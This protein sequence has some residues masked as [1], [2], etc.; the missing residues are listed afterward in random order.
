MKT[1]DIPYIGIKIESIPTILRVLSNSKN[2]NDFIDYYTK[3]GKSEKTASEYL[4]SLRNLKLAKKNS[5]MNTI[6][7]PSGKALIEDD[8]ELLYKNLLAHC[9]RHFP[10][11]KII[12]EIFKEDHITVLSELNTKLESRGYIIK[13]KQTLSSF[14]KLFLECGR[15]TGK[16]PSIGTNVSGETLEYNQFLKLLNKFTNSEK[17]K[18]F[19]LSD[20]FSFV[21]VRTKISSDLFTEYLIISQ[22]ENR[23]LLYPIN[24]ALIKENDF[25]IKIKDRPYYYFE[26]L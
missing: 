2:D 15:L 6:L 20:F 7:L 11:L 14:F 21:H 10:D 9:L 13:R 16:S 24:T 8:I 26:V 5:E 19:L 23:I 4:H 3:L 1:L 12:N 22:R 25:Y 18:K 17:K